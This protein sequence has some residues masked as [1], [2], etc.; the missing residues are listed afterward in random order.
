MHAH[1]GYA[2][3]TIDN[4]LTYRGRISLGPPSTLDRDEELRM[5]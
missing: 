3:G 5:E 2:D 1:A 4:F